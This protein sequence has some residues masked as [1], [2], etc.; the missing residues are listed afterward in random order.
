MARNGVNYTSLEVAPPSNTPPESDSDVGFENP[1]LSSRTR[2]RQRSYV[3]SRNDPTRPR[4]KMLVGGFALLCI[5]GAF[6]L[7]GWA[8]VLLLMRLYGLRMGYDSSSLRGALRSNL[9]SPMRSTRPKPPLYPFYGPQQLI[10]PSPQPE[11][12]FVDE[13]PPVSSAQPPLLLPAPPSQ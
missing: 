8:L 3:S 13:G 7:W 10:G 1:L 6:V 9:P 11:Q 5:L 12:S 4:R 2:R